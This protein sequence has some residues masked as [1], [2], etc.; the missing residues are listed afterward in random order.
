MI[1]NFLER[2][3]FLGALSKRRRYKR[4]EQKYIEWKKSGSVLPMP[5]FGKQRVVREYA[6]KFAPAVF[7]E[8]GT[9]TGHM[10]YAMLTKFDEIY[11]IELDHTLAEKAKKKFAGYR[12]VHIVQGESG[13]LLPQIL[14][15]ITKP[16]LFWLDARWS[17]GATAKGE[18]ETPIMQELQCILNHPIVERHVVLIDDARCFTGENGYPTL[19]ALENFIL[20]FCP[21]WI[22][23]VEHD[24]IRAHSMDLK[25]EFTHPY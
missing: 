19:E 17:G 10:V 25:N 22:F 20:D 9:Y 3:T 4:F 23:E 24:I 18:L 6:E 5:H 7:V 11:S 16:C 1:K 13:E 14:K 2:T 15:E 8:T 12:H 21:D